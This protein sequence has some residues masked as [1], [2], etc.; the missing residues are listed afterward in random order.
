[1]NVGSIVQ[2][3]AVSS[4]WQIVM[5]DY[6]ANFISDVRSTRTPSI[7]S[8]VDQPF[9][10]AADVGLATKHRF[11]ASAL[12]EPGNRI[13]FDTANRVTDHDLLEAT[14][15]QAVTDGAKET[16]DPTKRGLAK[17]VRVAPSRE[18]EPVEDWE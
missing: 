11:T 8:R 7:P 17:L 5:T 10:E 3:L 12:L 18:R 2:T 4:G 1:D 6:L 16:K 14:E 15:Y 9:F 13:Y